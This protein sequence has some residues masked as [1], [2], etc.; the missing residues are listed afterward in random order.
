MSPSSPAP[1]SPLGEFRFVHAAD[2]HLDSPMRGLQRYEGAPVAE[3]RGATRRATEKLVQ[4]CLDE[5]VAF[6]LI[7]GDLFDGDWKDYGTGLFFIKQMKRLKDGGIRVFIVRGN[8]DAQSKMSHNLR[9]PDNVHLFDTSAAQT[10]LI[11]DLG[12]AIHGQS[13]AKRDT[14][15]DLSAGYPAAVFGAL[16]IG[17]LHTSLDGR[18]GHAN[19]APCT[20]DGLSSKG[21]DYWALGHVHK[22]EVVSQ[23]P[24]I[25]F[26]GNLQGRHAREVG[27][28]GASLVTVVDQTISKVEH[29]I[30]DVVRWVHLTVDVSGQIDNEAVLDCVET[31]LDDELQKHDGLLVAA[32]VTI[33]GRTEAHGGLLRTMTH[34]KE[35]VRAR[36][37]VLGDDCLWIE[38]V[39]LCTTADF[40]VASLRDGEGP[41]AELLRATTALAASDQAVSALAASLLGLVNKVDVA[42]LGPNEPRANE[43]EHVRSLLNEIDQLIIARLLEAR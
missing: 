21:Y 26:P 3:L 11:E 24:W 2:L 7:A 14:K 37:I 33:T 13:Y 30:L 43:V 19:Y 5:Q 38:K 23:A 42:I 41:Y 10:V 8:H 20:K 40:C 25:V 32:R 36:A 22:R 31:A 9:L 16:N 18:E 6:L 4:L 12:L 34:F 27:P 28:K 39:E 1:S 15:N 29:R 17:V 35:E